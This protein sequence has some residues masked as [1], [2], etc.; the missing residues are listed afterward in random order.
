MRVLT[1]KQP[2]AWAIVHGGK[3]VENRVRNLAG[4]YRGPVAIH[5]ALRDDDEPAEYAHP[6]HGLI[7]APCPYAAR[8]PYTHNVHACTWCTATSQRRWS[9]QGHIIGIVNLWAVHQ[10]RDNGDCC[11]HRPS[12]GPGG[13]P[14]SERDVW[15]LCLSYSRPLAEPFP[16]RGG[17]GLR[18]LPD[19]V[20]VQLLALTTTDQEPTP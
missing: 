15:H 11:P 4:D 9:D 12:G 6:M 1:V 2:W 5:V 13:S 14:W 18:R 16:Y 7:H 3:D 20:A 8:Y 17:L 19:D 10:D